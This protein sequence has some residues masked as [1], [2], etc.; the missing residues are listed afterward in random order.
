MQ[1]DF[2]EGLVP[3]QKR[4]LVRSNNSALDLTMA[5]ALTSAENWEP[6]LPEPTVPI[7]KT[8]SLVLLVVLVLLPV[9]LE[10]ARGLALLNV[11]A[12]VPDVPADVLRE[13]QL[14][15]GIAEGLAEPGETGETE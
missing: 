8:S 4:I 1:P 11:P 2:A 15:E 7:V 12:D 10:Y 9:M 14:P 5:A 3:W 13:L 6:V